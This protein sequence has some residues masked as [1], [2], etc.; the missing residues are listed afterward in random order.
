V[1]DSDAW[2]DFLTGDAEE[3]EAASSKEI[4]RFSGDEKRFGEEDADAE[5]LKLTS[6]IEVVIGLSESKALSGENLLPEP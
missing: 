2:S 4:K 5:K 3:K 6:N 1:V